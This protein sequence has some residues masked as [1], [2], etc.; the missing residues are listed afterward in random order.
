M[1]WVTY[2]YAPLMPLGWS[3]RQKILHPIL[4]Q[5]YFSLTCIS[6]NVSRTQLR[7]EVYCA[8]CSQLNNSKLL[9]IKT[10]FLGK[11][12]GRKEVYICPKLFVH[13]IYLVCVQYIYLAIRYP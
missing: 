5:L 9:H 2:N 4:S 13:E 6:Q 3:T 7:K 12:E 8:L 10:I 11:I 1:R